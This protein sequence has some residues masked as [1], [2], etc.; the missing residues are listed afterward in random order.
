[1]SYRP[2]KKRRQDCHG[3]NPP[4][5]G[6]P[7]KHDPQKMNNFKYDF[8]GM[9]CHHVLLLNKTEQLLIWFYDETNVPQRYLQAGA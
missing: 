8:R 7:Q 6:K 9:D 5:T 1:M 3:K 4:E 2:E